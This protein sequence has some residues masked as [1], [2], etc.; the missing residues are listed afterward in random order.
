MGSSLDNTLVL[1]KNGYLN[2]KRFHNEC[3]RHKLLDFLGDLSL[4]GKRLIGTVK[5]RRTGH[6]FNRNIVEHYIKNPNKWE[7]IR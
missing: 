1:G 5:A 2:K 7:F 6:G 4:L 3:V